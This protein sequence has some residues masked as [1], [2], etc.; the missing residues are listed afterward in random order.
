MEQM[1]CQL[2]FMISITVSNHLANKYAHGYN[3]SS[4][5]PGLRIHAPL[6]L[7]MQ[8]HNG[9]SAE[10]LPVHSDRI[11]RDSHPVLFYPAS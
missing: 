10:S 1:I 5:F 6:R 3:R 11:A 7:L 9:I 2:I 4:R 8:L